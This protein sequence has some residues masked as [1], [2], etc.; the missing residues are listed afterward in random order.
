MKL[1]ILLALLVTGDVHPFR[2]DPGE[3]RWLPFTVKQTPAQVDCR[4]QVIA[5]TPSVH[6]ELLPMSEFRLFTHGKEH[7][8]LALSPAS[9]TGSFRRVIE[10]P[11][12]YAVVLVNSKTAPAATISLEL[13]VDSDPN[14][15]VSSRELSPKRRLAVI[16]I[17]FSL[18]FAIVTW[19]GL[20]LVRAIKETH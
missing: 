6:V 20:K 18:F 15:A 1:L 9:S 12:Q 7:D 8:S 13:K 3:Y 16:L 19:S 14:A 11:G 17:S 5:G 2:L 10:E 4:F